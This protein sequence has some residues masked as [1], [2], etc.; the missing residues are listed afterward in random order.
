MST[1]THAHISE[2][3]ADLLFRKARTFYA[4]KPEPVSDDTLRDIYNLFKFGP[5]SFNTSPARILFLRTA[6]A[7]ARLLPGLMPVNVEKVRTSPVTAII[8][9]DTEFYEKLPKLVPHMDARS[10]FA[11]NAPL[12]HDTAFRNGSLQGAYLIIA[13]RA[14]GL[15][16]G[17]MS[18]FDASKVNAEFFP[19]G[20]WKANFLCNLGHGD[21][22]NQFPR[23]PRLDFEEACQL[24]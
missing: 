22:T 7:K 15:D 17:P 8:A 21:A 24:L 3:D 11:G 20:K 12:I 23:A 1:A 18:G 6:E 5:T 4:W 2:E 14:N 9:Y 13:A 16:C 19:D 10:F